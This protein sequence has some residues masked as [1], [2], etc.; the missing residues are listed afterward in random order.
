MCIPAERNQQR[1]ASTSGGSIERMRISTG[2]RQV[3]SQCAIS[4]VDPILSRIDTAWTAT[5][6]RMRWM[7]TTL[8]KRAHACPLNIVEEVRGARLPA[9]GHAAEE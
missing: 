9:L 2:W 7:D 3:C 6:L 8:S 1:A 4:M 5:C